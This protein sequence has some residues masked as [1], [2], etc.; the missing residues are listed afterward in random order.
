M[1]KYK[2]LDRLTVK[3]WGGNVP[4]EHNQKKAGVTNHI[5]VCKVD[6][7]TRNKTRDKEQTYIMLKSPT[8]KKT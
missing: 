7:R 6:F 1:F 3:R 2:D 8:I 4:G 5:N